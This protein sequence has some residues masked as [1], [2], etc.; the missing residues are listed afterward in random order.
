MSSI[1]SLLRL[2]EENGE[3]FRASMERQEWRRFVQELEK[4]APGVDRAQETGT[5]REQ[6]RAYY[7]LLRA[8]Q[9]YPA[10]RGAMPGAGGS[11]LTDP[12]TIPPT[13]EPIPGLPVQPVRQKLI[14]IV[15]KMKE[16]PPPS[17]PPPATVKE[18]PDHE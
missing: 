8:L 17:D 18:A 6:I 1:Q 15:R 4:L 3:N 12:P 2:I 10:V 16:L 7:R 13:D 11:M 9:Q 14:D 5:G